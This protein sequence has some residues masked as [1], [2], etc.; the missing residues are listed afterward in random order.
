MFIIYGVLMI[1]AISSYRNY[2][3]QHKWYIETMKNKGE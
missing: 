2:T 1:G 3:L